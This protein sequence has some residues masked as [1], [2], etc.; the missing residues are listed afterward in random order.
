MEHLERGYKKIDYV[1]FFG[2]VGKQDSNFVQM[3]Q[4]EI[5]AVNEIILPSRTG[6][7]VYYI[8]A[9]ADHEGNKKYSYLI[10]GDISI[11]KNYDDWFFVNIMSVS[12]IPA[13]ENN[14]YECD[15][16][17]GLINLLKDK[18]RSEEVNEKI[19]WSNLL[20]ALGL[21]YIGISKYG[22]YNKIKDIYQVVNSKESI[23][24]NDESKWIEKIRT[25]AID[26]IKS[27]NLFNKFDK[28]YIID[29]IQSINFKVV[30]KE[31]PFSK[32]AKACYV[33]IKPLKSKYTYL[34]KDQ[35]PSGENF[36]IVNRQ[37]MKESDYSEVIVHEIYHYFDRLLT[38][39]GEMYS[40]ENKIS[41]FIDKNLDDES[42]TKKKIM[43]LMLFKTKNSKIYNK[44]S[45]LINEIV[46][47]LYNE[48]MDN[49]KYFA[50][51]AE[52]FA[53]YKTLKHQ[54]VKGGY[55]SSINEPTSIENI[56]QYLFDLDA[57]NRS[58]QLFVLVSLDLSKLKELDKLF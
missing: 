4:F 6:R 56:A 20:F 40:E 3:T 5:N 43:T 7:R 8:R 54:M 44:E 53:R 35:I 10:A 11:Y 48:Y 19:K 1:R 9:E 58:G 50:S 24:T 17:V 34:F 13:K 2:E 37:F 25:E 23:P 22:E 49:K 33:Y 31:I 57:Y 32:N 38:G 26:Q 27:S 42:Y 51:E 29:S 46:D 12:G 47:D 45:Q 28:K 18:Y 15:Q 14:F 30:D 39:N 36:I 55:I 21:A 41:Q 16:L 52:L